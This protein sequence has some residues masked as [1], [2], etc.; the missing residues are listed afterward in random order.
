MRPKHSR[1]IT[2]ALPL[3]ALPLLLASR[4]ASA[5]PQFQLSSGTTRCGQCH[6]APA[7]TGLISAWGRDEAG[8]TISR[9][10]DGSFLHGLWAPPSWLALGGDLR[11]VALNNDS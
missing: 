4:E 5:L 9:G 2:F 8:D 7:G 10:G 6:Y 3:L 11:L 1:S